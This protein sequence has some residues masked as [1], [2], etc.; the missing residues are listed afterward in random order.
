MTEW[1]FFAGV[2]LLAAV[3]VTLPLLRKTRFQELKRNALNTKI[4]KER[5]TE[6]EADRQAERIDEQEFQQLRHELEYGL[7]QDVHSTQSA[8]SHKKMPARWLVVALMTLIPVIALTIYYYASDHQAASDWSHTQTQL[9]PV[10]EMALTDPARLK[11]LKEDFKISDFVMV[12]QKELLS[13]GGTVEGWSML[14]RIY[15]DVKL[16]EQ[17]RQAALKAYRLSSGRRD[18][19][20]NLAH[21]EILANQGNMTPFAEKLLSD[22][23]ESVEAF[24]NKIHANQSQTNSQTSQTH[25]QITIRLTIEIAEAIKTR[26]TGK[27][28]LFVFARQGN[29]AGPPLAVKKMRIQNFPVQMELSDQDVMLQGLSIQADE[30]VYVTARL[31]L[32]GAPAPSAGDLEGRSGV[33]RPGETTEPIRVLIDKAL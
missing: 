3:A 18:L 26:L 8:A 4:F 13:T 25:S 22:A 1:M 2:A 14:S 16:Y 12:L 28:T 20:L 7:L 10:V 19:A 15:L 23:G 30:P 21:L 31:S 32:T 11:T 17:A 29:R 27:E 6:L 5:L 33:F 24:T 9:K